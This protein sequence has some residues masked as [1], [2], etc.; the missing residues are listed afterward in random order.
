MLKNECIA[1]AGFIGFVGFKVKISIF[2]S[3][4]FPLPCLSQ[5]GWVKSFALKL[6][7]RVLSSWILLKW[8]FKS[9][10]QV[11][12]NLVFLPQTS[13]M[14]GLLPLPDQHKG[15]SSG[16]PFLSQT[17]SW[18]GGCWK[19]TG[20]GSLLQTMSCFSLGFG[21]STPRAQDIQPALRCPCWAAVLKLDEHGIQN[22]WDCMS[23]GQRLWGSNGHFL[24]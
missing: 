19:S 14:S 13:G 7:S 5:S 11:T 21:V 4:L 16:I 23:L 6:A 2:F 12:K 9:K 17:R 10:P 18:E 15:F 20:Q 8:E 1:W 3:V 24:L 22:W